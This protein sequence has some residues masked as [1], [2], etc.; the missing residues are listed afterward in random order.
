[1]NLLDKHENLYVDVIDQPT[2]MI[3]VVGGEILVH[4]PIETLFYA[5][6]N[7]EYYPLKIH[8]KKKMAKY[9]AE[10]LIEWGGNADTGSTEFEDFLD[11]MFEDALENGE[12]WL[13]ADEGE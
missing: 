5:E 11:K 10:M 7:R 8:N 9:V 13:D 6:N 1:M 4:I 12:M 3:P 2:N